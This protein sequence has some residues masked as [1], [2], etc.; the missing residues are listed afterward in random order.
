LGGAV[1]SVFGAVGITNCTFSGNQ[2]VGGLGET[3]YGSLGANGMGFGGGIC[4][5]DGS[6]AILNG[7][8]A[9]NRADQGGGGICNVGDG[10]SSSVIIRNTILA[11]TL[12]SA[13]DYFSTNVIDATNLDLGNKNLIQ[14]NN[15]F[16]GVLV[17]T[18]DP[19]L[20]PLQ[21]NGGP[22]WTHALLNDSP[23]IEAGDNA[24]LPATDQRG[25]PRLVDSDGNGLTNVDLG[26][27]EDGLVRLSSVAQSAQ[28]IE[29]NGFELSLT[30]ETN[31]NYVIEYSTDLTN[32]DI[33]TTTLIPPQG[34]ATLYDTGARNSPL[35]R[36][37]RA[38]AVP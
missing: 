38:F 26:A 33:V 21:D 24:A 3:L 17:S 18:E 36:F 23:A 35:N 6:V 8:F 1:F 28:G 13:S 27:V 30:G 32:W 16:R 34:T 5:V 4:N 20:T 19:R 12:S 22:T 11:D 25:Y 14:V 31:R 15:G 7:T 29:V 9:Y 10:E 37:Y 2:A